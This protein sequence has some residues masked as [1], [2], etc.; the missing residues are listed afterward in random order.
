MLFTGYPAES[1]RS[2]RRAA[3]ELPP[4]LDDDR[5]QLEAF[6]FNIGY[7][8]VDAW[9]AFEGLAAHYS[10]PPANA[11]IGTKMLAAQ[12]TLW[13]AQTGGSAEE[14][15]EL[16][17]AA[18]SRGDLIVVDNA[19]M[20][21]APLVVL[22]MA[23]RPEA[24]PC[25]GVGSSAR[26]TRHGSLLGISSIHLWHG[27]TLLQY[28][29]LADAEESLRVGQEEFDAWGFGDVARIYT[30]AFHAHA[31]LSVGGPRRPTR[32]STAR[33]RS[34]ATTRGQPLPAR[35]RLALPARA[36]TPRRSRPTRTTSATT[37]TW[38]R[39]RPRTRARSWPARSTG[40]GGATRRS[41][42]PR[43]SSPPRGTGVPPRAVGASL[44][45]LGQLTG[46]IA[47]LE[48]AATV[49]RVERAAGAR[50]GARRPRLGA[51]ARAAAHRRARA[52]A[53]CARAADACS[54]DPLVE[55][56][57]SPSSTRPARARARRRSAA[58][59]RWPARAACGCSSPPRGRATATSRR[60]CSSRPRPSRSTQSNAYRKLDPLTARELAGVLAGS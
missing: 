23:D 60:R 17:Q 46:D 3:D 11:G 49:P 16:A 42:T 29:E 30:G 59:T 45:T 41:R 18:L 47:L 8:G 26:R 40:S 36:A 6:W 52:A 13:R 51:A 57:R 33:A 56:V 38:S 34:L 9:R 5:L 4:E 22:V 31:L 2:A 1:R 7:F 25:L 20:M 39:R 10:P 58:S 32:C 21:M 53:T 35:A 37:A 24:D 55:H 14:C 19:I 54:A 12:A 48:E 43:P 44:R 27:W 28:G 50:E 15:V